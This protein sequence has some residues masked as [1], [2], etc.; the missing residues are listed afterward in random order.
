MSRPYVNLQS[1]NIIEELLSALDKSLYKFTALD[2]IVGITLNGGLSRGYGDSLSEIDITVFVSENQFAEYVKGKFPFTLGITVLDGYLFDIKAANF[3]QECKSD[4]DSIALWD[5][6]YARILY[7]P[8]E[9]IAG[10]IKQKL[11]KKVSYSDASGLLWNSFW[12]YRLAGDIWIQR[13]DAIQGHFTFNNAI[14]PLLEALFIA[15]KEYTPHEKWLVHMSKTLAWLPDDWEERLLRAMNTGDFT[16]D[17][18]KDRQAYINGLWNDIN[19]KLCE[20]SNYEHDGLD[21]TQKYSY[22]TLSMLLGKSVYT[23]DEWEAVRGLEELNYE[24]IHS[25]F[26]RVGDR[27]VLDKDRFLSL[28][29]EDMYVWMYN[30]VDVARREMQI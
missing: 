25:V 6:S 4:Y 17:S 22:E 5:L 30:I 3:E 20:M 29:P 28:K 14:K 21:F 27:V 19:K 24:P 7:D 2:G 11:E 16:V 18:L 26:K 10:F 15:N 1:E 23:I 8:D 12:S 13:Q 9:K